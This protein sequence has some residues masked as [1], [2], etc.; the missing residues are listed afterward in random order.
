MRDDLK[1]KLLEVLTAILPLVLAVVVLQFAVIR[2]PTAVFLQFIIGAAMVIGGMVLFL[3]GVD[4]GILPMGKAL[5]AELPRRRSLFLVIGIAFVVGFAAT[6]AEP[7]VIVLTR[8]VDEVSGGAISENVL[9]YAIAIGVGFF[10]AM[11]MLRILLNLPIAHLLAAGYVIIIVLSFF[12]PPAFVPVA[13]DSGGVTTG[14]MAVPIILSLGLGFSSVLAGRSAMSD[15]FGLIGLAS[16]G[17]V[18]AVMILGMV[19]S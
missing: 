17:P 16:I 12:T 5:G 18:I 4:I 8:Q 6:V 15:G 2:M 10:V 9:I 7:D 11:A 1:G 3:V 14:P 19:L 13:F